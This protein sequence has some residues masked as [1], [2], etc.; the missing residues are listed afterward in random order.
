MEPFAFQLD[1]LVPW[2][3]SVFLEAVVKLLNLNGR[4]LVRRTL[5][6]SGNQV[7]FM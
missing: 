2:C 7:A 1:A 3:S 6:D 4:Q 5:S